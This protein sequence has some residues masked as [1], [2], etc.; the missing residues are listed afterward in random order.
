MKAIKEKDPNISSLKVLIREEECIGC[1]KCIQ[2]CPYDA[3]MG[4]SKQM[5][6]V[7]LSVCTG[8][9]LCISSCPV[10]CIDV[11]NVEPYSIE[12]AQER[13]FIREARIERDNAELKAKHENTKSLRFN[14]PEAII[15][16]RKAA[17]AASVARIKAKKSL[18]RQR[19]DYTR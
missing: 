14:S 18:V 19:K 1:T 3:I 11:I 12:H 8:C 7:L 9:E 13:L 10:D 5:H 4:A 6:T 15:I 2:A 17:I 16:A